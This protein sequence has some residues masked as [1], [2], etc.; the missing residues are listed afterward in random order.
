MIEAAGGAA[1]SF[2]LL[3]I[4]PASDL[5]A[6]DACIAGLDNYALAVFISPNA[7]AF[8]VPRLLA[9]RP[10]PDS[11]R[12]AAIGPGTVD[13]LSALGVTDALVPPER[14]DSE[15]L[16]ATPLFQHT[17]VAG[18]RVVIFRGDGGR[19]LLGD[20]LRERG[21]RVD[22]VSCY[23]RRAPVGDIPALARQWC[24]GRIDALTV[25]SSEGLRYLV[26]GLGEQREALLAGL[27]L[28]AP[29][30]RI[31]ATARALGFTQRV[32]TAAAD[33]GLIA[34]LCAYNWSADPAR[35]PSQ[36]IQKTP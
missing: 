13:A 16:L 20:T 32:L 5:T 2:P 22:Y 19:D 15:G 18:H 26:E 27:P 17:A 35:P 21:A 33:A 14:F 25:S 4:A 30:P 8:S 3:D 12:A 7:V 23:Q 11:L 31:I 29:H 10:W 1:V 36:K 6:L 28:F 9:Q 34:G 24:A